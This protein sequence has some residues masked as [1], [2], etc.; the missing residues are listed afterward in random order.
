MRG[1]SQQVELRDMEK[2]L[3]SPEKSNSST[4]SAG[5]FKT[6]TNVSLRHKDW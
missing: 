4:A 3:C 1:D 6:P 5:V 2:G